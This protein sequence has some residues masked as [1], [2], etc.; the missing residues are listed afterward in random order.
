MVPAE[1]RE[2]LIQEL[3]MRT[4]TGSTARA[5]P[6]L[7]FGLLWLYTETSRIRPTPWSAR[8]VL[9]RGFTGSNRELLRSCLVCAPLARDIL[10]ACFELEAQERSE[11]WRD[12]PDDQFAPTQ[13]LR[14]LNNFLAK[15]PRSAAPYYPT[16]CPAAP[17]AAWQFA[18]FGPVLEATRS[19]DG[20]RQDARH[21]LRRLR[22]TL[23]HGHYVNWHEVATIRRLKRELDLV[24]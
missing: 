11:C 3:T 1:L 16:E 20:F 24:E 7:E 21:E 13:A 12:L 2:K 15:K 19:C 4:P 6:L 9:R 17:D 5:G 14:E 18:S 8:A 22:N 10:S 23:S